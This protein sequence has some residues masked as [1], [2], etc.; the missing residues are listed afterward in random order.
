MTT[1]SGGTRN[2]SGGDPCRSE[3]LDALEDD[4]IG[5]PCR[6]DARVEDGE[7]HARS[8]DGEVGG[9]ELG[10]PDRRHAR[11][12]ATSAQVDVTSGECRRRMPAPKTV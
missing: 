1:A 10:D 4:D 2:C 11:R 6:E 5:R 9:G 3:D 12:P 8:D 7:Q